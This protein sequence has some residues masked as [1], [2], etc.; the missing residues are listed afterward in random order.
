MKRAC[1]FILFLA[2][3]TAARLTAQC[4]VFRTCTDRDFRAMSAVIGYGSARITNL[5][6]TPDRVMRGVNARIDVH[7]VSLLLRGLPFRTY[8]A[9]IGDFTYGRRTSDSLPGL[10]AGDVEGTN[11][12][13]ATFGYQFLAGGQL[14]GVALLGGLGWQE[15]YHDIGG[16]T[17]SGTSIPLVARV[18][19]GG[20]KPIVL[21]GWK[22]VSGDPATGARVDVPFFR[23]LLVTAMYWRADGSADVWNDPS[24]NK[25]PGRA[26]LLVIGFR[27][28]ELR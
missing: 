20:R 6:S 2:L 25:T 27:T 8:D 23:R 18:E 26:S 4:G 9:L 14:G 17:M 22:S 19:I 10:F 3:G 16:T 13:Q 5:G 11:G 21:T 7:V 12:F 1:L 28:A 24:G 15:Y